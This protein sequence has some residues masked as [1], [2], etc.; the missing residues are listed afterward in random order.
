MRL[1]HPGEPFSLTTSVRT[2]GGNYYLR[3]LLKEYL[4]NWLTTINP[5]LATKKGIVTEANRSALPRL[6]SRKTNDRIKIKTPRNSNI[7]LKMEAKWLCLLLWLIW[8]FKNPFSSIGAILKCGNIN[9]LKKTNNKN[10]RLTDCK[11]K[12]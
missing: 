5:R 4:T 3:N 7:L 8:F 10:D 2:L 12:P 1:F 9:V 11:L 6:E